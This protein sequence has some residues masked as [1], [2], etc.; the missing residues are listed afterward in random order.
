MTAPFTMTTLGIAVGG[1]L[2]FTGAL[3]GF[4][5]FAFVALFML[6]G[7]LAGRVLDGR[8]DLHALVDAFRGRR[9][10]S[11]P[12]PNSGGTVLELAKRAQ[13]HIRLE[14]S[15]LT[16]TEVAHVMVQ[17]SGASVHTEGRRVL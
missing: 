1:A 11:W 9:G 3:L 4:W 15:R 6:I 12:D 5:A 10:S 16:G 2:A 13:E 17:V 7:G 8:L 14:T